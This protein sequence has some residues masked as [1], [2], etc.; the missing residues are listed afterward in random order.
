MKTGMRVKKMKT[1]ES[2]KVVYDGGGERSEQDERRARSARSEYLTAG[3]LGVSQPRKF[4]KFC[5]F[6]ASKTLIS[7]MIFA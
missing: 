6:Q 4:L 7:S 3:G 2:L 5:Y 1:S